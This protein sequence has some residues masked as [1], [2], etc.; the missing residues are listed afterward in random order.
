[1]SSPLAPLHLRQ[2]G[3]F[4]QLDRV[5]NSKD[6]TG[7][8]GLYKGCNK[9]ELRNAFPPFLPHLHTRQGTLSIVH[10]VQLAFAARFRGL[11]VC[12]MSVAPRRAM[13]TH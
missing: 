2:I 3:H 1:M 6:R 11:S 7:L 8:V 10:V 12:I 5:C 9:Y 4:V 13:L